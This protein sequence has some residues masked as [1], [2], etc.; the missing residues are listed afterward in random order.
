MRH[1]TCLLTLGAFAV[2]AFAT[3]KNDASSVDMV[4]EALLRL[5]KDLR[6]DLADQ[7]RWANV[8]EREKYLHLIKA[9]E[10]FG[11]QVDERFP[12]DRED[13]LDSLD[14]LWLWARAQHEIK[15]ING[16]YGLFRQ[17]QREI[18]ELNAPIDIKQLANFAET[19][20]RD[21]NASIPRALDRIATLIIN[22]KLFIAAFQVQMAVTRKDCNRG[23]NSSS[24]RPWSFRGI[25]MKTG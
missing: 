14:S 6:R 5:E 13:H 25:I 2:A 3:I 12:L 4:R 20:L 10:R 16:L 24:P 15:G 8:E 22:E 1:F 17:M 9:Y 11:N 18:L 7:Q 23:D 21:P 19:I